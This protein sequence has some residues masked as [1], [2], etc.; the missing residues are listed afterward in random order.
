M[1]LHF[2]TRGNIVQK[3]GQS[4]TNSPSV[5]SSNLNISLLQTCMNGILQT[6]IFHVLSSPVF[7]PNI[8]L[9]ISVVSWLNEVM[10]PLVCLC[11]H[12]SCWVN[13]SMHHF[14]KIVITFDDV[15]SINTLMPRFQLFFSDF[16]SCSLLWDFPFL[17]K[18]RIGSV[19][20]KTTEVGN[21]AGRRLHSHVCGGREGWR[22]FP[23]QTPFFYY[24]RILV[25]A[26]KIPSTIFGAPDQEHLIQR[27]VI[28]LF[29][30]CHFAVSGIRNHSWF[31]D[32]YNFIGIIPPILS[33]LFN[34]QIYTWVD[35]VLSSSSLRY[36]QQLLY[37]YIYT[38]T[39]T[40]IC[41]VLYIYT[42]IYMYVCVCVCVC[43]LCV[44]VNIYICPLLSLGPEIKYIY[45][46]CYH[47]VPK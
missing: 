22:D 12:L 30:L 36:R 41:K 17:R 16:Q 35:C 2:A 43:V 28:S 29:P 33:W 39:L 15:T 45:V 6:L 5:K 1:P 20:S 19:G 4:L 31:H 32:S 9:R 18:H 3:P 21:L 47:W 13:D 46:P 44:C 27:H 8:F 25:P 11:V 7:S 42:Y 10:Q 14:Q 38:H 24:Y 23:V 26:P 40:Y 37:I 34:P